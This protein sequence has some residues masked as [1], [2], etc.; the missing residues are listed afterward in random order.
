[1]VK[2]AS[3]K[4]NPLDVILYIIS[5]TLNN[6]LRRLKITPNM[7]TTAAMISLLIALFEL[8]KHDVDKFMIF[9]IAYYLLDT[10]SVAMS[11]KF[12]MVTDYGDL[13]KHLV[14][15][16]G[17]VLLIIILILR[18]DLLFHPLIL[19]GIII[20]LILCLIHL[21]CIEKEHKK[22]NDSFLNLLTD[23]CVD[24]ISIKYTRFFG[25]GTL[26]C[27]IIYSVIY[28]KTKFI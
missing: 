2:V 24:K 23:L 21:G 25:S 19:I 13:Y 3:N 15:I 5:N 4:E 28:L 6:P 7:L 20:L 1:M 10:M 27:F 11:R 26:F 17:F 12:K 18:Y 14:N 16:I 8:L 9:Y 22:K